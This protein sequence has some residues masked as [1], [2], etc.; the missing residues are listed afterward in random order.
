MEAHA[1]QLT[2]AEAA[3]ADR[4]R[5][6]GTASTGPCR[7]VATAQAQHGELVKQ[8]EVLLQWSRPRAR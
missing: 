6:T 4:N 5:P 3:A 2:A 7:I 8:T 1:E